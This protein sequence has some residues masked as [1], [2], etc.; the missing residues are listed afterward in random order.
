MRFLALLFFCST[1]FGGTVTLINDSANQLRAVIRA[2]DGTYLGEVVVPSQR[3]M[4]WNNYTGGVGNIQ[5]YE[6]SQ[7]P[8]TVAWF[9]MTGDGT[10]FSI[11]TQ[12]GSGQTVTALSCDGIKEC[13]PQKKQPYPPLKGSQAENNLQPQTQEQQQGEGPPE[14]MLQ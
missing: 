12:V 6:V 1:L 10:P 11:C 14:G 2:A 3:T 7:T 13:Q 4:K 5:Y 9:C 8:Y